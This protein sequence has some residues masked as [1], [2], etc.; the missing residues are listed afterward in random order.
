MRNKNTLVKEWVKH[1]DMTVADP[2]RRNYFSLQTAG[3]RDLDVGG[4]FDMNHCAHCKKEGGKTASGLPCGY[5][6]NYL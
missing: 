3:Y 1:K 6:H 2:Q 5:S 4:T